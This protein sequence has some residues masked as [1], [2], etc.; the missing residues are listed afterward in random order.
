MG[1]INLKKK[2]TPKSPKQIKK[3]W[4]KRGD[5]YK[6]DF[7]AKRLKKRDKEVKKD[8]TKKGDNIKNSMSAKRLKKEWSAKSFKKEWSAKGFKKRDKDAKRKIDKFYGIKK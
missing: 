3:A 7:S 4:I 5:K 6:N 8:W 1:K 2:L